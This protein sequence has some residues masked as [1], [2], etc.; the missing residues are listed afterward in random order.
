MSLQPPSLYLTQATVD[1]R[2]VHSQVRP[3]WPSA[4][5]LSLTALILHRS[6]IAAYLGNIVGALLVG[7]PALYFY[8]PDWKAGGLRDAEAGEAI[9]ES[10]GGTSSNVYEVDKRSQ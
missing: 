5:M 6:L 8:A 2:R 3:A 9:N 7:L 1:R 10:E 4:M